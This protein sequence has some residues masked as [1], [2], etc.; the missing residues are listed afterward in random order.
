M[1]D[2]G[3]DIHET[4]ERNFALFDV[5]PKVKDGVVKS[6]IASSYWFSVWPQLA[7][8]NLSMSAGFVFLGLFVSLCVVHRQQLKGSTVN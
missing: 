1:R 8:I 4:I 5:G 3:K 2:D 6:N 7:C